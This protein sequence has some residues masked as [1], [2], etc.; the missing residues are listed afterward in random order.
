MSEAAE[1]QCAQ[2]GG[3][4]VPGRRFCL[5]CQ[6]PVPGAARLPAGQ[7]GE[8]VRHIPSTHRP[9]ETLVFVPERRAA[10]LKR[11]RR[12]RRW[13]ITA[14]VSLLV[15][16]AAAI[17]SQLINQYRQEQARKQRR[18][19]MA[20]QEIESYSKSLEVFRADIGRYPILK[21]GLSALFQ[22]P[23]ELERWRGPYVEKD[24]SVDPWGNDYIYR[25]DN[26]GMGYELFSYGPEGEAG[27]QPFLRVNGGAP[28]PNA[29]PTP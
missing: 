7:L 27:G 17:T 5:A 8:I 20:R 28:L 4:L 13:L 6:A 10:R 29:S 19:Q 18:E 11:E 16:I 15:I 14:A 9:D 24:F 12:H 21:E 2:C 22:R 1:K 25:T 3:P 26:E 23:S